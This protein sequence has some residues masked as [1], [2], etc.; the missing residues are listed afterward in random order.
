MLA[1]MP[2]TRVAGSGH[3][4]PRE[5][6]GRKCLRQHEGRARGARSNRAR[7]RH[8]RVQDG[9]AGWL[10]RGAWRNADP[11]LGRAAALGC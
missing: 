3:R 6:R 5:R 1:P 4:G 8:E 10:L 11:A 9:M 2:P 7:V